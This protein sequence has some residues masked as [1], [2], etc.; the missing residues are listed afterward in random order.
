MAAVESIGGLSAGTASAQVNS[1]GLDDFMKILLTQLTYQDPLKPMDNQQFIAQLAQ[2]T[3]LQQTRDSNQSL[4]QLL[5]VQSATQSI[6]LLGKT[7]EV[8]G[9]D[10]SSSTGQVTTLRFSNG[11]PLL[12]ITASNGG[13]MT[14]VPLSRISLVR[15]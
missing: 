2:F 8:Q 9:D 5:T 4:Q 1:L 10:G 13:V 14:D 11:Q 12:T 15:L 3:S 6:G 7:V